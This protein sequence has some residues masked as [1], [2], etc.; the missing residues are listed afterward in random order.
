M[1]YKFAKGPVICENH[2]GENQQFQTGMEIEDGDVPAGTIASMLGTK[3][4]ARIHDAASSKPAPPAS[5]VKPA[6]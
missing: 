6:A 2:N 3:T 4:I 1:R 5:P